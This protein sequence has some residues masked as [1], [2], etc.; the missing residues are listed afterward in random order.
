MKYSLKSSV[1]I[2]AIIISILSLSIGTSTAAGEDSNSISVIKVGP[3]TLG[4]SLS[5][6]QLQKITVMFMDSP[7][8]PPKDIQRLSVTEM[9][10]SAVM[11]SVPTSVWTYGCS[12]TSAGMIFG[13]YDRTGYPNMYT[14]PTNG[15]VAPLHDLGQGISTPIAG[16]CSIIATQNGFDG[17]ATRGHVDDYW[18]GY[19]DPGPDPWEGN[20]TEHTWGGCTA[21]YMGTNQ[22][23]WDFDPWSNGDGTRET[24][25]DGSTS[26]FSYND[27]TKL[28]DYVPP[29]SLGLPQTELCHGLR[30]FAESR[31]YTVQENYTQRI[32]PLVSGGFSLANYRTEIDNGHPVMIQLEGHTMVGVGYEA[33]S[34]TI[35]VNDTWDNSVHPMTWGGSYSGM[36]HWGVTIIHLIPLPPGQATNPDPNNGATNVSLAVQLSWTA[37][38]NAVSHDVYFGTTNPP[39]FQG[40]QTGTTFN[41][42]IMAGGTTHYWR[43]DEKNSG[44]TT[45]GVVW[46][47]TTVNVRS[48]TTS[49]TAGG[50]V[51]TPGIGTF[52]YT[53]EANADIA[54]SPNT[55]Y[56]F[57]NWTGTAVTAGKVADPN[58]PNTT[59]T[60]SGNYTICANFD[61][62]QKSL[63]TSASAGGTVS[64]P[65]IGTY[66]YA[67]NTDAN[68]VALPNSGYFFVNWTGTAVTA[69]KVANP[70]SPNTTVM[71]SSNYTIRANFDTNLK[72]LT[73]S[74]TG[75]GTVTTPGV[76]TYGYDKNTFADITALAEPNHIFINWTGTAVTAGKVANPNSPSTTVL[77]DADRTVQANFAFAI[78]PLQISWV[79]RYN[80]T[81]NGPDYAMDIAADSNGNAYVTGYAKNIGTDYDFVTIKYTP[82]GNTAWAKIYNRSS[83]TPDYAMAIAVDA[84]SNV[85]VAGYDYTTY[86]GYDGVV[87]K[88]DSAG[89]QLWAKT[90]NQS[91]ASD[92]RLSDVAVDANGN[93]YVIGR[94]N[95][96]C[97]IIKYTPDGTLAWSKTYNGTGNNFDTFYKLAIDSS[98]N[99]YACGET[100]GAGT[101]QDGLIMK[102]SPDGT[103]LWMDTYNGSANQ[104]DML[105]AIAI[106]SA[107]NI[108]VTGSVETASDCD[109]V[110]IKYS[111]AG[112]R[113]WTAF[114]A[115]ASW[116]WDYSY[117]I[118]VSLDGNVV[119]TGYSEGETSSDAATVK[120]DSATG[121]QIWAARYNGAGNATDYTDSI[122]TD[123]VGNVYVHGRSFEA[124]S[125]DYLTICYDSNGNERWRVNYN[126]S[127]GLTDIGSAIAVY[128]NNNI[129]VT[130]CSMNSTSN[131][132]YATIKYTIFEPCPAPPQGDLNGDCHVNF[133]DLAIFAD[134]YTG[135]ETDYVTLEDI[136]DTWLNCG[137]LHQSECWQ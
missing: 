100:A 89:T 44:G 32:D 110:T 26:V 106:D 58:S 64:T 59:V 105:E 41:S 123:K 101:Y 69:G 57:V 49:T 39:V 98:G 96:D 133:F 112:S 30:L 94:T 128:D 124:T 17:R 47:F 48:L 129:Y 136:A 120:Y 83:S 85:I 29:S 122:A 108:Y 135:W 137:L 134:G 84:N 107:D 103:L 61:T 22:W 19:L 7:P 3:T 54:A 24:N 73:T 8:F 119:V 20:W 16:S 52:W 78:D 66:W 99:I 118:A 80:G 130:G 131:Y 68:V 102:Y 121:A 38:V 56:S 13:Y 92:D 72:F 42:E 55:G 75:G 87:V 43:I 14:G 2:P 5:L 63:A 46:H 90:Y 50:T 62:S 1:I 10:Q 53:K 79:Q 11:L 77:I 67:R 97:L 76:G 45:T 6:E 74:A 93:V 34:Q 82:D 115:G 25:V 15:G 35:Y 86:S 111:P 51:S 132:D 88:Y 81:V 21:D 36:A 31:G 127:A 4:D 126:G 23:K 104:W 71:M 60:M 125:T 116:G 40:N 18:T 12:A 109:Y 33:S 95:Q 9:S 113:L 70:S 65:G 27:A 28:Y 117:A 114:Y 37:G 91:G